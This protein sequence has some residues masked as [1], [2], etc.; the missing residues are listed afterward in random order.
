MTLKTTTSKETKEEK[1]ER[2]C[3]CGAVTKV[4]GGVY[5]VQGSQPEPYLVEHGLCNCPSYRRCSHVIAVEIFEHRATLATPATRAAV[6][7]AT[8]IMCGD[9]FDPA[10]GDCHREKCERCKQ[11][12]KDYEC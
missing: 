2:L 9:E 7:T 4:R 10:Y 11:P 8:C 5:T 3:N 1:G 12:K 6:W